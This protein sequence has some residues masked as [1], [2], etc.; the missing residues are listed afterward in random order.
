MW[1]NYSHSIYMC[2]KTFEAL[3][4]E[5]RIRNYSKRTQKTYRY[6]NEELLRFHQKD[7]REITR[8]DVAQY[9]EYMMD[10]HS[11]STG[12][13]VF[14][15]L[16]FY[17][18]E[19]LGKHIFYSLKPPKQA[20]YLPTVLSKEEVIRMIEQVVNPKHRCMLQLLYG[21]GL[22]VAELTHLRMRDI[23]VER[24]VIHVVL[25]KGAKD[26]LTLLPES[27]RDTIKIQ[28]RLKAPDDFLFTSY[29]NGRLTEATVQKVVGQVAQRANISKTVTPH[30]LRHSFATHLLENG[31]DI[32]Y[33]QELLG[34]SKLAT[35]QIY[36]N[37]TNKFLRD[38]FE[39]FHN[40]RD[41][42]NL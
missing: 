27:L 42:S 31:T 8:E 35:T 21:A 25:G 34:H 1:I 22:R 5:L 33:I 40:K 3:D 32:R 13:V 23:D 41:K 11:S 20:K 18:Q 37:V 7:S 12:A 9:L 17:Y 6:Y 2:A 10:R 30:T 15:A 19:V 28:R 16:R 38:Q 4:R 26:R 29:D 14:N 24:G 39:K 36:T